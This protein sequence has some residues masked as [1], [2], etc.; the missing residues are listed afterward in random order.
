MDKNVRR[1]T[2]V[3]VII[4]LLGYFLIATGHLTNINKAA[5]AMFVGTVGWILYISYGTD[6]VM[7]RH[8]H[9]YMEFLAGRSPSSETVKYYIYDHIFLMYLGKTA[10][11][12]LFLLATMSIIEI[13]NNNG[14]FDF[15]SEWVRTRNSR[16]FIWTITLFT[17]VISANLDNLT[18]ST[19]MLTI[20]HN[21]VQGRRQR[22]IIGCAIV[23]A[24]NTGG[25]FTVI[26]DPAGVALWTNGAVTATNFSAYLVLPAMAAWVLPTYLLSRGLPERLDVEWPAAR[27]R[28]DDTNLTRWQRLV[29]LVVGIGGLWF[30]PTFHNI[31]KLSPFLGAL[32]VLSVLW[33][34][35]EVINRK[36]LDADRMIQRRMPQAL[37]YD[38]IQ[39]ILFIIGI[40]LGMGAASETGVFSTLS[41]WIDYNVHN[42]W[43]YGVVAGLLS[44]MVDMFTIAMT[45]ISMYPVLD[46]G[47]IGMWS[48]SAYMSDFVVNGAYWKIIAY[49]TAV[50]G[51][52]VCFA[53]VSGLALMKIE[54][55]RIGWYVKHC[56]AKIMVGWLAGLAI[57]WAEITFMR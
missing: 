27:Y 34:V 11:I 46:G 53:N 48:D 43:F 8:P 15:I 25:C 18:T 12:V 20:M 52:L 24:A 2:L 50:G 42:V 23:L 35:D 28:G 22:L 21:I 17:F 38:N 5:I 45:G 51:C 49:S 31:T 32:C 41:G 7:E 14:C 56:T 37:R 1:M 9:E 54:R 30:I 39:S 10:S 26:G 57:L 55:M 19:M 33:V 29:M 16:R 13:L 40:M 47:N 3:I 4:L 36:L 44:G 6:F